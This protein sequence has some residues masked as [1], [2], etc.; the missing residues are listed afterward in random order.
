MI[1]DNPMQVFATYPK[2][3]ITATGGSTTTFV[4]SNIGPAVD[5]RWI[6]GKLWIVA[7]AGE[8]GYNGT[9]HNITDFA[10][11]SGTIT[12]GTTLSSALASGD[13]AYICPGP[14]W[15]RGEYSFDLESNG[16]D[17]DWETAGGEALFIEQGEPDSFI[18]KV[19]FRLHLNATGIS[20]L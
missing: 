9:K 10:Q 15:M 11:A 2:T 12:I 19:R 16:R 3:L 1:W 6:G 8:S 18:V 14:I 5:D 7:H 20:A 13:T 4:D 17:I